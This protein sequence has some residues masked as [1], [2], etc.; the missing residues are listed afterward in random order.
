MSGNIWYNS[1][2]YNYHYEI[3]TVCSSLSVTSNLLE[4]DTY[5]HFIV[6]YPNRKLFSRFWN[7]LWFWNFENRLIIEDFM[8]VWKKTLIFVKWY[9][10]NNFLQCGIRTPQLW[11]WISPKV[12]ELELS[13]RQFFAQ[14][15]F[16]VKV[17]YFCHSKMS[18][19][20]L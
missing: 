16:E 8:D 10:K 13:Y 3:Y 19:A 2:H 18:V 7:F 1:W 9:K 4:M 20:Q 12:I 15:L 14:F 11:T 6:I 5:V 17:N